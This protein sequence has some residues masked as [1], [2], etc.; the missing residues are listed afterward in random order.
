MTAKKSSK[1]TKEAKSSV[2]AAKK[3]GAETPEVEVDVTA[4]VNTKADATKEANTGNKKSR[5]ITKDKAAEIFKKYKV[6]DFTPT[7]NGGRVVVNKKTITWTWT[8]NRRIPKNSGVPYLIG[9]ECEE[10]RKDYPKAKP[11]DGS[12]KSK[13]EQAVGKITSEE[14]LAG[15]TAK[16]LRTL[17]G[18]AQKCLRRVELTEEKAE[19]QALLAG[20]KAQEATT[21]QELQSK[22]ARTE[23]ALS[24]TTDQGK[25]ADQPAPSTPKGDKAGTVEPPDATV[26]S[27]DPVVPAT[28]EADPKIDQ[29]ET[30]PEQ[31][32]NSTDTPA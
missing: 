4:A 17:V 23:K 26:A 12:S 5:T 20:M 11:A 15:Y 28:T 1:S 14:Q 7:P 22:L 19:I 2:D 6:I 8:P 18:I 31:P 32:S 30:T 16:E 10:F 29:P 27:S 9:Q 3:Q 25:Q 13:K 24:G 21:V